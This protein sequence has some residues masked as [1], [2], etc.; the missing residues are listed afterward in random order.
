MS[1]ACPTTITIG[2]ESFHVSPQFLET[3]DEIGFAIRT[4][5]RAEVLQQ[6]VVLLYLLSRER[7]EH[8]VQTYM[9]YPNGGMR[10]LQFWRNPE[11]PKLHSVGGSGHAPVS[12]PAA[13]AKAALDPAFE[14]YREA[15]PEF[16]QLRANASHQGLSGQQLA[17]PCANDASFS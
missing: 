4:N 6:A 17:R 16:R 5:S 2:G 14:H 15:M 7:H 10:L 13:P 1:E 9:H 12:V 11:A 8:Q 3:L